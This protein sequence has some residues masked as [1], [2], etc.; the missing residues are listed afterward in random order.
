ME[1]KEGIVNSSKSTG[2]KS[3]QIKIALW[4][5]ICLFLAAAVIITYTGISLYNT[6]TK[7]AEAQV[8][9]LAQSQAGIIDAEIETALDTARTLAQ[10]MAA[11]KS[12]GETLSRE[13]VNAML[14]QVMLGNPNFFGAYTL[15][16]PNAFD[17]KDAEAQH[18]T[19]QQYVHQHAEADH[20]EPDDGKPDLHHAPPSIFSSGNDNGRAGVFSPPSV[21]FGGCF[22]G[23]LRS[24]F[25]RYQ[26]PAPNT[27]A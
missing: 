21:S 15:W 26:M 2:I 25:C 19:V 20:P 11:L 6:A 8:V 18:E 27:N 3:I 7:T 12:S 9:A 14:E 24:S 4:A 17:G 10:T 13:Q 22:T 5:G 1:F 16:E 23:P